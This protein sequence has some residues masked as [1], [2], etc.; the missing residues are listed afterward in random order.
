[1]VS[2]IMGHIFVHAEDALLR[3]AAAAVI[4]PSGRDV[5]FFARR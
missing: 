1:M 5:Y 3:V 4:A 2:R